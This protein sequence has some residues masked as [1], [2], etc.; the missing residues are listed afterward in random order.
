M[1]VSWFRRPSAPA[2]A[3]DDGQSDPTDTPEALAANVSGLV[4]FINASA[5]KLPVETVV[6]SR[7]VTDVLREVVQ[8]AQGRELDI[9]A[10][11]TVKAMA[12]DYLPTTLRSYLAL[13]PAVVDV[14]GM[15]GQTPREHLREQ[16]LALWA[17]AADVLEASTSRDVDAL[18]T[19]GNFLQTKFGKSDLDL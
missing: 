5:G 10:V 7:R 4:E 2:A 6:L 13:D 19:Q 8:T 15:A 1:V 3:A 18:M 17:A 16:V 14:R 11:I 9:Y 12:N